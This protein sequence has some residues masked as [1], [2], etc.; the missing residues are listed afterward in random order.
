M[1]EVLDPLT[2][3]RFSFLITRLPDVQFMLQSVTMP[4]VAIQDVTVGTSAMPLPLPGETLSYEE[5]QIE[6]IVDRELKNWTSLY[7]WIRKLGRF[8]PRHDIL[9]SQRDLLSDLTLIIYTGNYS[10]KTRIVFQDAFPVS[11]SGFTMNSAV[12]PD[13]EIVTARATL[14]YANYTVR[15]E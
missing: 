2:V 7:A 3:Q 14:R 4:G 11:L 15:S 5:L 1:T 9:Q 12:S 8:V 10:A 6:F 13:L